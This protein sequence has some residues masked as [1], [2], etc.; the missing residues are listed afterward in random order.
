MDWFRRSGGGRGEF[1]AFVDARADALMGYARVL[2]PDP[3]LALALARRTLLDVRAHWTD[4]TAAGLEDDVRDRLARA[5]G[6]AADAAWRWRTTPA[7]NPV[8][9]LDD[10]RLAGAAGPQAVTAVDGL[11]PRHRAVLVSRH[12]D[13]LDDGAIAARL[14]MEPE[15]VA[16]LG[17]G[18]LPIAL[19][20]PALRAHERE[21]P[22]PLDLGAWLSPTPRERRRRALVGLL[23]TG[24]AVAAVLGL[25]GPWGG[26]RG[27][28]ATLAVGPPPVSDRTLLG[29]PD[30]GDLAGQ[31]ELL[32]R[33]MAAWERTVVAEERPV[34]RVYPLLAHTFRGTSVFVLEGY[35]R[36]GRAW[37]ALV[38]GSDPALVSTEQLPTGEAD[39]VPALR[40]P[41]VFATGGSA[42]S[43]DP[44]TDALLLGWPV[45]SVRG[46]GLAFEPGSDAAREVGWQR[47]APG[48]GDAWQYAEAAG[49]R[50]NLWLP[51]RPLASQPFL[52]G[53]SRDAVGPVLLE[54]RQPDGSVRA[55]LWRLPGEADPDLLLPANDVQVATASRGFRP[56][57]YPLA[58]WAWREVYA[59]GPAS[60]TVLARDRAPDAVRLELVQVSRPGSDEHTLVQRGLRGRGQVCLT[61]Q[62]VS[63]AGFSELSF[64]VAGCSYQPR[65]GGRRMTVLQ[66][67]APRQAD[68]DQPVR[69]SLTDHSGMAITEVT[70]LRRVSGMQLVPRP[71]G[72]QPRLLTV[73]YHDARTFGRTTWH[74]RF[75]HPRTR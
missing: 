35:D 27:E 44:N 11:P 1:T 45:R 68:L 12:V 58:E 9:T 64:V 32:D 10:A 71:G 57:D 42:I 31:P 6:S 15:Q 65:D 19:V 69:V 40:V 22:T 14:G 54:A 41:V 67:W 56:A 60:V 47:V 61:Q 63:G 66:V 73:S 8:A 21:G 53:L 18:R 72:G 3:D 62:R 59:T 17:H 34:G 26:A 75:R 23:A 38:S 36:G 48:L 28:P 33:A 30:V 37:L 55:S 70:T 25:V 4:V 74:W 46:Q 2:V 49:S 52:A 5:A 7:E 29:W 43:G 50:G 24:A 16:A 20:E 13:R 51:V 39:R